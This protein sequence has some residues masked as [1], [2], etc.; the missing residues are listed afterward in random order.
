MS[1]II[2]VDSNSGSKLQLLFSSKTSDYIG[3]LQRQFNS[4]RNLLFILKIESQL[5]L[6]HNDEWWKHADQYIAM[7]EW[8]WFPFWQWQTQAIRLNVFIQQ[9]NVSC[10]YNV[11]GQAKES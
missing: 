3:I 9:K 5:Y 10:L 4:S 8:V 11:L 2:E 7:N 1:I 6:I